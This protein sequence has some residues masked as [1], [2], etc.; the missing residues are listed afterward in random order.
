MESLSLKPRSRLRWL[1]WLVLTV[2]LILS[3]IASASVY[4]VFREEI[5]NKTKER[6]DVEIQY[7]E[8]KLAIAQSATLAMAVDFI[9]GRKI[10]RKYFE[11]FAKT[12]QNPSAFRVLQYINKVA[13]SERQAFETTIREEELAD[14]YIVDSD[15]N[16]NLS[17]SPR[18]DH[19]LP[20]VYVSPYLG[21]ERL[22]GMDV[23][24]NPLMLAAIRR[25]AETGRAAMT[26]G[27]KLL[28]GRD[29]TLVVSIFVPVI[30]GSDRSFD[31]LLGLVSGVVD[32]SNLVAASHDHD[33]P[34]VAL[35]D[36]TDGKQ[37]ELWSRPG[38]NLKNAEYRDI[39]LVDRSWRVFVV[40]QTSRRPLVFALLVFGLGAL[41]VLLIIAIANQVELQAGARLL[42][43][44]LDEQ[45]ADLARSDATY[46]NLFYNDA[47]ANC[48]MD[49]ATARFT[50]VNDRMCEI[51]GYSEDELLSRS[52]I[53]IAHPDDK[54]KAEE[55]L[56]RLSAGEIE[57]FVVEKR[58]L[59]NDGEQ[60]WGLVS[61]RALRDESG[62]PLQLTTVIHDITDRKTAEETKDVLLR[63]LAHRVRNNLQLVDS[64]AKQTARSSQTVDDYETQ[65]LG[66]LRALSAAHDALFDA[67]WVSVNLA[68]VVLKALAPF[69]TS[70]NKERWDIVLADVGLTPQQAQT[71][72]LA[73]HELAT[74][75]VR[76]GALA[77]AQGK[78]SL[79]AELAVDADRP[80]E[81][82]LNLTW[83]ESGGP[84]VTKPKRTGF[85]SIMLERLLARQHGGTAKIDWPATGLKFQAS[86]P[87][88]SD[89]VS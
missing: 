13:Y 54:E 87:L 53:D 9:G 77:A 28:A 76:F 8:N 79:H 40:P 74:N 88:A 82:I 66:R 34:I 35:T 30:R 85:G 81:K 47:T 17:N 68:R 12:V 22:R 70:Q 21:N 84:E 41:A 16:G 78:V 73:I 31:N 11:D 59:K 49:A 18:R 2:G 7:I 89:A 57:G 72:A 33:A 58:Y 86:L 20:I 69:R 39:G 27:Y 60:F 52:F 38:F 46:R 65:L 64:L 51:T 62:K 43:R 25:A 5:N 44:R 80:G 71:I 14:F 1:N 42:G 19:Y 75:A 50:R 36:I 15:E 55:E 63:E 26:S 24:S 61:V 29:S 37:Q 10:T 83:I 48:E 6:L 4:G 23:A 56:K 3:I 67:N 32:L 45:R